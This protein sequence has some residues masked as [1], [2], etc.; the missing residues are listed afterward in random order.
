M[1]PMPMMSRFAHWVLSHRR[2]VV[3][4]WCGLLLVAGALGSRVQGVIKG[5]SDGVPGSPSVTTIERAVGAGIPAGTFFPFLVLVRHEHLSVHDPAFRDGVD[6]LTAALEQ[7]A[8]GGAVQSYWSTSRVDLLGRDRHTALVIFRSN[9]ERLNHAEVLTGDVRAAVRG[10]GLPRGFTAWVTGTAPMYFDLDRQSA[11][12]LLTAERIGIPITLV[13][14]LLAFRAPVA[15]VLP[16]LLA[17]AAVTVGSAVLFLLS[18]V[19]TVSVFSLNVIS[20]IG[21]GLG[22]DYALFVVAGVRRLL[23]RGHPPR[24][25]VACAIGEAGHAIVVSGGAVVLAFGSLLLV[26]IPFLGSLAIAGMAIVVTAVAAALTLLPAVLSF[27]GPALNWPRA[28]RFA[29]DD[30]ASVWA[31]WTAFVMRRPLASLL[32]SLSVLAV[33]LLPLPRLQPWNIG[34]R[35]LGSQME[36]REGYI[37]LAESFEQGWIGPAILQLETP[38]ANG[39]WDP[40]VQQAVVEIADRLAEDARVARVT[41]FPDVVLTA[42]S[43][44]VSAGSREALPEQLRDASQ[45][46]VSPDGHLAIVVV[47]PA[48]AAEGPESM[49]LLDEWRRDAWPELSGLGVRVSISGTAAL[50]RDFDDEVFG[51][52]PLVVAALLGSTFLLLLVAFRSVLVPLKAILLTLLS[53]LA[54]YGFLV[55]VF[56]DGVGAR[57]IGLDAPGGL[58]SFIVLVLFT[59]LFGLSMDYEVFLLSR[60]KAEYEATGNDRRAVSLG[61]SQTAG[62][63]SSAAA[64]MVSI[65]LGFGFTRL[66]ATRQFGLGLAFAVALDAT[67]V[68]LVMVPAL[69]ALLGGRNWWMPAWLGQLGW[70]A[71]RFRYTPALSPQH[72]ARRRPPAIHDDAVESRARGWRRRL[73]ARRP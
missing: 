24:E 7:V 70:S 19:T 57:W 33:F 61:V 55:Y 53:V 43:L 22:V 73:G 2:A 42:R 65:F 21:L 47:V 59:I 40:A 67:L 36:A 17:A 51:R 15:A 3:V 50:T 66:V 4:A 25:A 34:V 68:R 32:V 28:D 62:A 58:N 63:I 18:H 16:L 54:S 56:Q 31:R 44:H 23:A 14:L 12:D 8:G 11:S 37:V 39:V 20:M 60:V 35:D 48:G 49:A 38:R 10:A 27:A 29:R 46:V 1:P 6:R 52:M 9:V 26:N 41:G 5:G 71:Q 45:D 72:D 64:I 69:M 30:G 13:I